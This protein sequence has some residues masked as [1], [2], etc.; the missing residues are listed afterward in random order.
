M[1]PQEKI[2]HSAAKQAKTNAF[3]SVRATL[4]TRV[5]RRPTRRDYKILKEEAC[6]PVSEVED[7]TYAWSNNVTDNHGLLADILGIDEY[8]DLTNISM[9]NIPYEPASYDPNI[10]DATLTHTRK[11]I[12]KEGTRSDLVVHPKR[13]PVRRCQQPLGC[14]RRAIL[15]PALPPT[16]GVPQQHYQILEHLNNRWCPLDVKAKKELKTAY[17]TKWDHAVK[18]LMAFGKCLDNN[19]CSLV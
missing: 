8:K 9:Y 5:H 2:M 19:H 14:T 4:F 16:N 6:A 13:L 18:H 3:K 17:Y 11:R 1:K 12:E 10:T 15:F 7:I